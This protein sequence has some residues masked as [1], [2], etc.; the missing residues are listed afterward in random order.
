MRLLPPFCRLPRR[1]NQ[2]A[3]PESTRYFL[4]VSLHLNLW[5]CQHGPSAH[6]R[7]DCTRRRRGLLSTH[8]CC[9][10][11]RRLPTR[12]TSQC[13]VFVLGTG[14]AAGVFNRVGAGR[15]DRESARGLEGRFLGM[16]WGNGCI[17]NDKCLGPAR[18]SGENGVVVGPSGERY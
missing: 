5:P 11:H 3:H 15:F 1:P 12:Y 8:R 2:L 7:E 6:L 13:R 18:R 17:G 14:A 4:S 10:H 16:C 9:T